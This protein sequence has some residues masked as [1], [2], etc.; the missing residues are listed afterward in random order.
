MIPSVY[1]WNW[2]LGHFIF[3]GAFW[4]VVVLMFSALT[5]AVYRSLRNGRRAPR[6]MWKETFHDL[7]QS[8]KRCRHEISKKVGDKVCDHEFDCGTCPFHAQQISTPEPKASGGNIAL[9]SL[10]FEVSPDLTY[11]RGHTWIR[12]EEDETFAIGLDDFAKRVVGTPDEVILPEIGSKLI[13]NENGFEIRKGRSSIKILSP[14]EGE[15]VELGDW[16]KG[17][18]LRI[19]P[20]GGDEKLKQL[21]QGETAVKWSVKELEMLMSRLHVREN[22]FQ[23]R[24]GALPH[25]FPEADWE[26]IWNDVFLNV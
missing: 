9:S 15:V 6:I 7:P 20:T 11:H 4:S 24:R 2:D 17:W 10:G 19:E 5:L 21:F 3:M 26:N 25:A 18:L 1:E 14:L 22:P 12:K 13:V 8:R 23:G 16:E